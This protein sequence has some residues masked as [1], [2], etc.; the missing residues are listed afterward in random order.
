MG[1]EFPQELT[2]GIGLIDSQH[3]EL[4]RLGK[5]L[6]ILL[7]ER[8]SPDVAIRVLS[9]LTGYAETHFGIEEEWMER[10]DYPKRREHMAVH[11]SFRQELKLIAE[12]VN[13]L[14][15]GSGL[16]QAMRLML[17]DLLLVHIREQDFPL[18]AFLREKGVVEG[19]HLPLP[20]SSVQ[21]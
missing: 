13:V 10:L 4:F 21:G 18:A 3:R 19:A 5:D 11:A 12:E 16:G 8:D 20:P 15:F 2:T 17:P 1:D 9:L 6:M 14:G 7:K